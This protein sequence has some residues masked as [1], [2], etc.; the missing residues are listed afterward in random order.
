LGIN[1]TLTTFIAGKLRLG[2]PE[3]IIPEEIPF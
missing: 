1:K 3:P 2:Y